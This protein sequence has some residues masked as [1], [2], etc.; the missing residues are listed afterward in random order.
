MA[1]P[2]CSLCNGLKRKSS[3]E[4]RVA[5]DCNLDRLKAAVATGCE[6]CNTLLRAL[7]EKGLKSLSSTASVHHVYVWGETVEEAGKLE[8]EVYYND[9]CGGKIKLIFEFFLDSSK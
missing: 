9:G 2:A 6:V 8:A 5:F 7:N 1:T 3:R 4:Y